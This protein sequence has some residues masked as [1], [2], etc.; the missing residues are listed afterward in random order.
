MLHEIFISSDS[1][2]ALGFE[3]NVEQLRT[4]ATVERCGRIRKGLRCF[5]KRRVAGWELEGLTGHVSFL[6]LLR[7]ETL[8]LFQ[9]VYR[10]TRKFYHQQ[11]P[12]RISA[13]AELEPFVGVM[14]LMESDWAR[15]W[16]SGVLA[17][18]ASLSGY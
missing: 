2:R 7:R 17:S 6:G 1:G 3:V 13:R 9:C 10:F 4:P 12:F 11:E 16:L 14:I 5:V 15:V 8:L 18:D